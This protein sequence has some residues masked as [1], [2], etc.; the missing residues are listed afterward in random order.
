MSCSCSK[1]CQERMKGEKGLILNV[2]PLE[3]FLDIVSSS[4]AEN[5]T[6]R[7]A[8]MSTWRLKMRARTLELSW[9]S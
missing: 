6:T 7:V 1:F 9:R 4:L 3:L 5:D 8:W 2:I